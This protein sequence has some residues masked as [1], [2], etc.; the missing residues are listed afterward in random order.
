MGE[1]HRMSAT[2]NSKD[3]TA[4]SIAP[5]RIEIGGPG[6]QSYK[7]LD[8]IVWDNIPP[9]VVLTGVNGSGKTQLLE[10]MAYKLADISHQQLGNLAKVRLTV[11]GQNYGAAD[12]AYL[13]SSAEVAQAAPLGLAQMQQTKAN[14]WQQLQ[15]P[16]VTHNMTM[17]AMRDRIQKQ[18]GIANL[19]SLGQ[20]EFAKRLPDDFAF[21]LEESDVVTGLV[22]VFVAHRLRTI[23]ELEKGTSASE[24][25]TKIGP[26]PWD[27]L[28]EA[29]R[30]A[31]FPYRVRSPVGTKIVDLYQMMLEDATSGTLINT[32]DLSSGEKAL[33]RLVLWMYNSQN[34]G[35]RHESSLRNPGSIQLACLLP[36]W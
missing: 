4:T 14:L 3:G 31:E 2:A 27:V 16:N 20:Q 24:I 7:S 28:N 36:V 17:K 33:F 21:M 22:H 30:V 32:N 5:I 12:V 11:T 15:G 34:H 10:I 6:S 9:F 13:P 35:R 18:L 25:V 26:A 19:G 8:H 1:P 29:F 23:E